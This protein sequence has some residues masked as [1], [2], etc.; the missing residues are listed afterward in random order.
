MVDA[1]QGREGGAEAVVPG[2]CWN[3][4][5]GPGGSIKRKR[6]NRGR[7]SLFN[8]EGGSSQQFSFSTSN[9]TMRDQI[10][11]EVISEAKE[12]SFSLHCGL[13]G[14][15]TCSG[16]FV[17]EQAAHWSLFVWRVWEEGGKWGLGRPCALFPRCSSPANPVGSCWSP[18]ERCCVPKL[19]EVFS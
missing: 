9:R 18:E 8:R 16:H 2:R 19:K 7:V 11:R 5:V 13:A 15:W 3:C 6:K 10:G 4:P 17:R 12:C 14:I 1:S